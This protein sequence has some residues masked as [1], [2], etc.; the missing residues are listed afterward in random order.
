MCTGVLSNVVTAQVG[1][2]RRVVPLD[3]RRGGGEVKPPPPIDTLN[4]AIVSA[5]PALSVSSVT[6]GDFGNSKL[7][8]VAQQF[9]IAV[10]IPSAV[11]FARDG[12]RAA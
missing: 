6:S 4:A 2:L 12:E 10:V 5:L 11:P 8:C 7:L 1:A 3:G 9:A